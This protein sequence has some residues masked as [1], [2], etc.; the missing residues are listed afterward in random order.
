M[1]NREHLIRLIEDACAGCA[2]YRAEDI[3]DTLISEG[4]AVVRH[5]HWTIKTDDYDCEYMMCSC[6]REEL[7]NGDEDTIDTTPNYCPNC[8]AK[9][10]ARVEREVADDGD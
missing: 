1:T 2:R 3:A 6:C 9:M 7:Y 5:G 8:G 4:V 10:D